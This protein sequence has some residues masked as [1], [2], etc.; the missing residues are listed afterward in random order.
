MTQSD[1]DSFVFTWT[2]R[3]LIISVQVT[4][5]FQRFSS[6]HD[7]LE[8]RSL[9]PEKQALPITETGYK[10]LWPV[11]GEFASA[12]DAAKSVHDWLNEASQKSEWLS[13][14]SESEQLSLF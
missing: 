11:H 13:F 5:N 12:E 8:V 4:L 1:Q 7:H 6:G 2:F 3:H 14:V 10:S 9:S